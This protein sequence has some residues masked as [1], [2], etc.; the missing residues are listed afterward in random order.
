MTDQ[1][2]V[3]SV[4]PVGRYQL[5]SECCRLDARRA[6]SPG[7][8]GAGRGA[9]RQPRGVRPAQGPAGPDRP[10]GGT[11]EDAGP[12][13]GAGPVGPDDGLPVHLLPRRGPADGQ[14][15]GHHPRLWAGRAGLRR[16]APVQLRPVR[17]GR[18]APDVRRQRL[19]RDAA[20]PLGVGRQTAGGQ[21]GGRRPGQR[22][23]AQ[24]ASRDR[25]GRRL[26]LP[27]GHARVRQHDQPGRLVRAR[28]RHRAA[29]AVRHP[30]PG[31]AAQDAGPGP[32]QGADQGQHAG[33]GQAD[34]DRSTAA[35]ASS[36]TRRSWSP[37]TS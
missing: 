37:S 17:L 7:Q 26:P 4:R 28:R 21:P 1:M 2:T 32:G 31:A 9:T 34:P 15:P 8:G 33:T 13:P 24:A 16:R 5:D 36:P 27:A 12:R 19:R 11:G 18:T 29:G 22:P 23:P 35:R 20:R 10:P 14:R 6:R 3:T 30:A 25:R